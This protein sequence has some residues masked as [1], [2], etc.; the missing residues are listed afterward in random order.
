MTELLTK[1]KVP[2]NHLYD[3]QFIH[4]HCYK[5]HYSTKFFFQ[6]KK[7]KKISI[8]APTSSFLNQ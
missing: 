6:L 4:G 8:Y 2:Q 5:G 1:V 7:A 3:N